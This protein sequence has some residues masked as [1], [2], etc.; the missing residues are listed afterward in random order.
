MMMRGV[1]YSVGRDMCDCVVCCVLPCLS[2][3][4]VC[5]CVCVKGKRRACAMRMMRLSVIV[6]V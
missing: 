2:L 4:R 5:V 6:C 1:I 3:S